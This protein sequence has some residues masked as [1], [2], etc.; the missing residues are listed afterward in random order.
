MLITR[1][2]AAALLIF[3]ATL[4]AGCGGGGSGN[5]P[6]NPPVSPQPEPELPPEPDPV[7]ELPLSADEHWDE[8]KTAARFLQQTTFGPTEDSVLAVLNQGQDDWLQEQLNTPATLHLPL[9]DERFESLGWEATPSPEIDDADGYYRDLQRSDIWWEVVLRS[10]DQLRQRVAFA[11]SQILVISN[12][13]DVLYNDTRG[14]ASYQDMLAEHAF[15]NYRDLLEAVTLHPM[16]GEYLSMVRNEKANAEHN[17]RPDENYA[18]E[19]MQLFS[20]GLVELNLDGTAKTDAQGQ[21]IPSYDQETIKAFARVFTG[22]NFATTNIWWE[23]TSD[24][25][26]EAL[27]MK[28]Y[29]AIHDTESKAL[30]NGTVLPAG[31]TAEQDMTG[32][33]DN[34]FN[35]PNVGPFISKQLIQRLVTSN[36]SP[37]YVER[38]ASV[39]NNNGFGVRGDLQAVVRTILTDIEARSGHVLAPDSFGKLRE[40]ILQI[41]NVWRTFPAEGTAVYNEDES[42]VVGKRIRYLGSDRKLGQRPYGSFSVFNF[43]RP[44]YSHPGTIRNQNLLSPE[45]Q[46]HTESTMVAKTNSL[47]EAIYWRDKDADWVQAQRAGYNWDIHPPAID[48]SAEKS[49]AG[50]AAALIDRLNLLLCAGQIPND[51]RQLLIENIDA[52]PFGENN[53][54]SRMLRVQ[55]AAGVIAASAY[56]ALQR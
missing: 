25:I 3:L 20:I 52:L 51:A 30:L 43:Y 39:F 9:L 34:L 42:A 49:I 26:G 53:D 50:D 8:A 45:F 54:Y 56:F 40:P 27:P 24:A 10:P 4:S 38:V 22:W 35:H 19:V 46:I 47:T 33:M 44:G 28:A 41:A 6:A 5:N 14:I 55:E 16:M 21:P 37:A 2:T 48:V 12:V 31:Q 1:L 7:A 15:G 29:Q 17:I 32:A 11:L 13:S 23:W 18:R 36:P